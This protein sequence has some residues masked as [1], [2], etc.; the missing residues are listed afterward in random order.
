MRRLV[1]LLCLS[2]ITCWLCAQSF[3]IDGLKYQVIKGNKVELLGPDIEVVDTIRIPSEVVYNNKQYKVTRIA[4]NAFMGARMV[5][6][7]LPNTLQSIGS[8]AFLGCSELRTIVIPNQVKEIEVEAFSCCSALQ[9]ITI[10]SR[11]KCLEHR[12]FFGCNSLQTVVLSKPIKE[13]AE[14]AFQG[15]S[16]DLKVVIKK[17]K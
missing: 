14:E 17:D 7:E 1:L 9:E 5:A 6:I 8:E 16:D 4:T 15:C 13:M 3:V 10:P 11:V 12:V 2:I